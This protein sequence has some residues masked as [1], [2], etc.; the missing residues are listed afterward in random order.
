MHLASQ[1]S[2]FIVSSNLIFLRLL[3]RIFPTFA[4]RVPA[5]LIIK[6]DYSAN[7]TSVSLVLLTKLISAFTFFFVVFS[8]GFLRSPLVKW[9]VLA[10][11]F[12]LMA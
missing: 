5:F 12:L 1:R 3:V 9:R 11:Q 4:S 2:S 8:C 7:K 10:I 6:K